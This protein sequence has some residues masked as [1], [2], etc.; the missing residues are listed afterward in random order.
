VLLAFNEIKTDGGGSE[1]KPDQPV[2]ATADDARRD[3]AQ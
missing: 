3:M 1:H 2:W